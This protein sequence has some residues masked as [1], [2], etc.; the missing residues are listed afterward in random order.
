VFIQYMLP[1]VPL[2]ELPAGVVHENGSTVDEDIVRVDVGDGEVVGGVV[3]GGCPINPGN[4]ECFAGGGEELVAGVEGVGS[5]PLLVCVV[6][7][8]VVFGGG[9]V[10]RWRR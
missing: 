8:G 1:S 9:A 5:L 10:A 6:P 4:G 3:S 7:E 2:E